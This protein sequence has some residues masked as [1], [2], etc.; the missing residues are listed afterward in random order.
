[1]LLGLT[2]N[3]YNQCLYMK[4]GNLHFRGKCSNL[5]LTQLCLTVTALEFFPTVPGFQWTRINVVGVHLKIN[6]WETNET[7]WS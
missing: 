6:K 5:V 2:P 7:V 1:M 4:S 3:L